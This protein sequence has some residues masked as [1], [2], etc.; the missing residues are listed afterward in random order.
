MSPSPITQKLIFITGKGG[1]GRTTI[2]SSL[3]LSFAENGE[4]T[5]LVQWS[6]QDF[7]SPLWNLEPCG[8]RHQELQKNL[9][10]MNF[11]PSEAM[12]E[13]FVDHLNMKLLYTLVLQNKQVQK[14]IQS[15]PGLEELFFVG[16]LFWL[17]ELAEQEKGL[18]FDRVVVDA[19]ATGHGAAL[20]GIAKTISAFEMTGPLVDETRRVS[21]L[22]EDP[23]KT[24]IVTV[25]LPEELPVEETLE[26]LPRYKVEPGHMPSALVVNRSARLP[27]QGQV[28]SGTPD[29]LF[30][31]VE[32][33]DLRA[34]LRA[35]NADLNRRFSMESRLE[36]ESPI[37]VISVPDF[38]INDPSITG[39][40][41]IR[42]VA[43]T[44]SFRGLVQ[45][46]QGV[47]H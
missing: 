22:L 14:L 34:E 21:A 1:V 44:E 7:I 46:T 40:S 31:A 27:D 15:A 32:S 5:L 35:L 47:R 2:A 6:F 17:C 20:F 38:M 33:E 3:G 26:V 11:D 12:K 13:Y 36:Q 43:D 19:P 23:S 25:S 8:H 45:E 16:R 41:I 29:F 10:V 9:H 37:P 30:P 28:D 24:T 18:K 39:H 42:G 4:N